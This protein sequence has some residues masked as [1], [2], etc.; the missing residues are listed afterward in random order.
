MKTTGQS[1]HYT[2]GCT[3]S[4]VNSNPWKRER[5]GGKEEKRKRE[6]EG[7]R[8]REREGERKRE[9]EKSFQGIKLQNTKETGKIVLALPINTVS[10]SQYVRV[11]LIKPG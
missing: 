5:K 11:H 4:D 2:G 10:V 9:G 7:E 3:P 8:K 1:L 6:R